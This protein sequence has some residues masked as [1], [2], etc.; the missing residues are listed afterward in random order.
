M[1]VVGMSMQGTTGRDAPGAGALPTIDTLRELWSFLKEDYAIHSTTREITVLTPGFLA[2]AIYRCGVWLN[3]RP[4][5][6]RAILRRLLAI[7]AYFIRNCFGISLY[8]SA[9]IGRRLKIAN[10]SAIV[11]HSRARIGDDCIIRQGVTIGFAGQRGL[12]NVPTLG[13]RVEVGAGAI[14][15]GTV[16]IGDDVR[17]ASNAVVMM[18][19][20]AG[21][22]VATPPPRIMAPPPR[23]ASANSGAN[24]ATGAEKE[25]AAEPA[26][27]ARTGEA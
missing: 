25:M 21:S 24:A 26:A 27:A 2:L 8:P 12:G 22:L 10:H 15:A 17:I 1:I 18:N 19:V 5:L 16:S 11:I 9:S 14:I 7:P 23:A 13:D 20:P 6:P 4:K 3:G